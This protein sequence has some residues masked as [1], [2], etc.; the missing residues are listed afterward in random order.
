MTWFKVD[1]QLH[2]HHKASSA[3]LAAMGMWVLAGSWCGGKRNGGFVP[4]R[5]VRR[6]ASDAWEAEAAAEELVAVGL[7][8]EEHDEV[9]PGW[10]FHDWHE[11]NPM[12][13]AEEISAARAEA[14][15]K[16]G[17]RSG[18]SRREA[19]VK[20]VASSNEAPAVA[21]AKQNEAPDPVPDPVP[22]PSRTP[23]A[24]RST[25]DR[26]DTDPDF[27]AFWDAFPRKE[28]K[29]DAKKAWPRA[30]K[31]MT[32]V[33]LTLAAKTYAETVARAGTERQFIKTPAAWLNAERW[34]DEA[35]APRPDRQTFVEGW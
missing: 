29:G 5:V 34:A 18:E 17:L 19:N 6:W 4:K 24:P 2:D 32:P 20:Q 13:T 3:S 14:G 31:K 15:R 28:G 12:T 16:G 10:R 22:D 1:D 25:I 21:N 8:D 35:S 9:E 27:L 33:D 23:R 7:W 26:L 11:F 30:I